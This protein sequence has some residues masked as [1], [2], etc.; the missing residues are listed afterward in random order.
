MSGKKNLFGLAL[1]GGG[2]LGFSHIGVL[3]VLEEEGLVPAFIAGTS[4]GGL[5]AALYAAGLS[6]PELREIA[7]RMRREDFFEWGLTPLSFLRLLLESLKDLARAFEAFPRGL[8]RGE[9]LARLV[10]DLVGKKNLLDLV[11]PV[12]IAAADLITG[13]RVVFTNAL[14]PAPLGTLVLRSVPLGT[15]VQATAAL[16]GI[17]PP[18][19]YRGLLLADGGLVEVVPVELARLIGARLV[20]AVRLGTRNL[21]AEPQSLIQV[22]LRS[23]EVR[24]QWLAERAVAEADLVIAPLSPSLGLGDFQ[25][26]P[27]L[28]ESGR[29]AARASLPSLRALLGE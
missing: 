27:E 7:L 17:F 16:P 2:L 6:A 18:V 28:L 1:G 26:I 12:G 23:L 4:A 5:V 10:E 13:R 8:F 21:Q 19:A 9:R 22:L 24:S 15:A 3:E 25:Y 14:F 29:E 20:V 11:H